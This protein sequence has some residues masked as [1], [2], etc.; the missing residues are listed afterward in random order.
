MNAALQKRER[1]VAQYDREYF[2]KQFEGL[3]PKAKAI[4]ALRAAMRVL[5]ML[6]HRGRDAGP[7]AYWKE[8]ERDRHALAIIRCYQASAFVNSLTKAGSAAAAAT[9]PLPAR[10]PQPTSPPT[11][12]PPPA[13]ADAA[14]SAAAAASSAADAATSSNANAAAA[15]C[16]RRQCRQRRLRRLRRR[17]QRCCQLRRR[18]QCR[19][20]R[21]FIETHS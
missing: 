20:R 14:R 11:P 7:F 1:G 15:S 18:R 17:R 5:P 19:R 2:E 10:P 3:P 4:I 21:H 13:A 16:R 9:L 6:A 12:T 8:D